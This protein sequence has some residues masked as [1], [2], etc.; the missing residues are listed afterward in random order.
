MTFKQ[1]FC[2]LAA[3][4]VSACQSHSQP[5]S[6]P[7]VLQTVTPSIVAE[8]SSA[9]VAL[10]GGETPT[11]AHNVFTQS[12]Q[13]ILT[14]GQS[15]GGMANTALS[16]LPISTFELQLRANTCVLYYP[17]ANK[18]VPLHYATCTPFEDTSK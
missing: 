17:K 14:H 2:T 1:S 7:A 18:F 11:L 16:A 9:I 12:P 15:S 4:L 5:Q 6:Q 13:L 3:L 8:I 10:K